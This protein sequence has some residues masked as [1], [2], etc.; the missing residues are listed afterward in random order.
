M[1]L[2]NLT[3]KPSVKYGIPYQVMARAGMGVRGAQ[4]PALVRAAVAIFWYGVQTY[5]AS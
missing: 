5:F 1:P 2:V 3:G 4:F